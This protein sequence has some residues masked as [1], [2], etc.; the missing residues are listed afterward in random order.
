MMRITLTALL[1]VL[2]T[3]PTSGQAKKFDLVVYGGTAGGV[4]S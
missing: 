4:M 1:T 3:G 2:L